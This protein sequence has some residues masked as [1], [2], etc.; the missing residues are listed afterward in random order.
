M[1]NEEKARELA[2]NCKMTYLERENDGGVY[3]VDSYD[4]CYDAALEM[5]EWKEKQMIEKA[6][7]WL[8]DDM[9]NQNAFQGRLERLK[10]IDGIIERFKQDMSND[11]DD[12]IDI[13][14]TCKDKSYCSKSN[15]VK[16]HCWRRD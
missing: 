9:L 7:K 11:N 2:H 1:K 13:C 8:K 5:A 3:D 16:S 15:Y 10:I 6:C 14:D 12:D 4:E